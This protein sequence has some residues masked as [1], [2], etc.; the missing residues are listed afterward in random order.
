MPLGC[1]GVAVGP[2][3]LPAVPDLVPDGRPVQVINLMHV[4][5]DPNNDPIANNAPWWMD[6]NDDGDIIGDGNPDPIPAFENNGIPDA[7]DE[8]LRRLDDYH[9]DGWRRFVF[10]MPAGKLEGQYH[11]SSQYWTLPPWK[12]DGLEAYVKPW[13]DAHRNE[14]DPDDDIN[15]GVYAGFRIQ[16]PCSLAM[17]DS[18]IPDTSSPRDMCLVYQ[19]VQPWIDLGFDEVWFDSA[20]GLIIGDLQTFLE[21]QQSPNYKGLIR[22][23]GQHLAL[24]TY[25]VPDE[26]ALRRAPFVSAQLLYE[27]G[28]EGFGGGEMW[29]FDPAETEVGVWFVQVANPG[30]STH[31]EVTLDIVQTYVEHG[32]VP[33]SYQSVVNEYV[34]CVYGFGPTVCQPGPPMLEEVVL[35]LRSGSP[36]GLAGVIIEQRNP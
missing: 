16:N 22:L 10:Y 15:L 32:F 12:R 13:I 28:T 11:A 35:E 5:Q 14:Q 36:L 33:W 2:F 21:L 20:V 19:N 17:D 29:T 23:G 24:E 7:F 3:E 26:D 1:S 8:M 34:Q 27:C 25:G 4:F 30:C 18:R 31:P 6:E 9:D